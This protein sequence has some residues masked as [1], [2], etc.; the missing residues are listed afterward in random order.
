[1]R[2]DQPGHRDGLVDRGAALDELISAQTHAQ[3]PAGADR[4]TN[5]VD[6]LQQDARPT[7][8]RAAVLVSALVG[9]RGEEPAD[10]G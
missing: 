2:L 3:R 1:M 7:R 10:D 6:D 8:Q 4:L 5:D 9:R